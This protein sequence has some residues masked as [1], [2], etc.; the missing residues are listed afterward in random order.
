MTYSV[1][2]K[3]RTKLRFLTIPLLLLSLFLLAMYAHNIRALWAIWFTGLGLSIC[4]LAI[5]STPRLIVVVALV[6]PTIV[7]LIVL[8]RSLPIH[9]FEDWVG[10]TGFAIERPGEK[11]RIESG[12]M[13]PTEYSQ[14]LEFTKRGRYKTILKGGYGYVIEIDREGMKIRYYVH[15]DSIGPSPGGYVQSVFV[16]AKPGFKDWFE[17]LLKRHGHPRE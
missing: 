7:A 13:T 1:A 2:H 12:E 3:K 14:L 10:I 5:R 6:L 4:V 9:P 11:W 16:P 15:G 8:V 17:E